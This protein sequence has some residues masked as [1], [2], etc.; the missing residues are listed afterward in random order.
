[1]FTELKRTKF[2]YFTGKLDKITKQN[3]KLLYRKYR[4]K[5]FFDKKNYAI[6]RETVPLN[7]DYSGG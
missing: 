2:N 7:S 1:M 3:H 6:S 5:K 4:F